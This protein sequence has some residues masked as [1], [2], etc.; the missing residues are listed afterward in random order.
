MFF[1]AFRVSGFGFKGGSRA[2]R[3]LGLGHLGFWACR[4]L[5]LGIFV[6]PPVSCQDP[7]VQGLVLKESYLGIQNPTVLGV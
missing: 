6:E 5:G 1:G 4:V 3:V 7:A 2:F